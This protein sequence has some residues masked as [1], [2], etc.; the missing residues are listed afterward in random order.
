[1]GLTKTIATA[2]TPPASIAEAPKHQEVTVKVAVGKTTVSLS[3]GNNVKVELHIYDDEAV[4]AVD[5]RGTGVF[6][7]SPPV[8]DKVSEDMAFNAPLRCRESGVRLNDTR[9]WLTLSKLLWITH[10][11]NKQVYTAMPHLKGRRASA[12]MS[13]AARKMVGL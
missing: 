11:V 9:S 13:T 10:S 8:L 4:A 3:I 6:C 5:D 7:S 12:A 2:A 1:V